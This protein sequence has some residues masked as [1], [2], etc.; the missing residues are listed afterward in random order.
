M[1][2]RGFLGRF[3]GGAAAMLGLRAAKSETVTIAPVGTDIGP[4]RHII[5]PTTVCIGNHC[6]KLSDDT[7]WTME[8]TAEGYCYRIKRNGRVVEEWTCPW[9][10][11]VHS[12]VIYTYT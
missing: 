7:S 1:N 4:F 10:E 9:Q 2:R 6:F 8:H 12:Y 5:T 11:P 3:L